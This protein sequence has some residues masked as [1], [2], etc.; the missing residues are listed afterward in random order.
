MLLVHKQRSWTPIGTPDT[1][2][3]VTAKYI[4]H[5]K[6]TKAPHTACSFV[7]KHETLNKN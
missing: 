2:H 1:G 4:V 6:H 3:R 7:L 5:I